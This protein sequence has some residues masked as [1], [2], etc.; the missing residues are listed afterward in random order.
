MRYLL[1]YSA[2]R[3]VG[4]IMRCLR[5][6]PV[7]RNRIL[8]SCHNGQHYACNPKYVFEQIAGLFGDKYECIWVLDDPALLP[9]RFRKRVKTVGYLSPGHLYYLLTSG[10]ILTNLGIEPFLAKR[11]RQTVISTHHGG[12]SYKSHYT[13]P[14]TLSPAEIRYTRRLRKLR[15]GLTDFI[16]AGNEAFIRVHSVDLEIPPEKFLKTGTPRNDRFF[17][18]SPETVRLDRSRFCEE[19]GIPYDNLLV[20]YAPTFRG[21]HRHKAPDCDGICC[22]RIAEAFRRRFGRDATFLYRR[23][24][25]S[26]SNGDNNTAETPVVDVTQRQDMQELIEIADVLV[27]DYSST[28]WDFC[29]TFKPGFLYVSDLETF[30]RQR[31]FYTPIDTWPYPYAVDHD[32]MCDI[33]TAYSEHESRT[34][35]AAHLESMG[36]YENGTASRQ[37]AGIIDYIHESSKA[38]IQCR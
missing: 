16:L 34:R 35:I 37:V 26:L 14:G 5:F 8:F 29:Q 10:F 33:I 18:L 22:T 32:G 27:T 20:L 19:Y 15:A 25:H 24:R 4:G 31:D 6:I 2:I 13:T 17:N 7:R 23:H 36:T 30:S 38:P 11:E 28:I 1:K 3:L 21:T 9:R 12:G